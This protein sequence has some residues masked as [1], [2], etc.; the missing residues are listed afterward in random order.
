MGGARASGGH[1]MTLD[2]N[3]SPA[4]RRT[5]AIALLLI[6]LALVLMLAAPAV[7]NYRDHRDR[8]AVLM[9]DVAAYKAAIAAMPAECAALIRLRES[10]T[11]SQIVI[12]AP[13]ASDAAAQFQ[14]KL[15]QI[16]SASG[17][18]ILESGTQVKAAGGGLTELGTHIVFEG[19][20]AA[21]T[22]MLHELEAAQP[23]LIIRRSVIRDPDGETAD[24]AARPAGPNLLHAE[25]DISAFMR[26]S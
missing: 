12:A 21:V 15:A 10:P 14:E 22:R 9:R 19:D 17:A 2:W 3:A 4:F 25:F 24:P 16:A 11:L 20:I 8:M 6:P 26:P 18:R 1:D 5:A 13:Q 23:L 7:A